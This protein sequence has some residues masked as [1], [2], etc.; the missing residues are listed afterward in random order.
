MASAS[1]PD[2][3]ESIA[4]FE[5]LTRLSS[6]DVRAVRA[7]SAVCRLLASRNDVWRIKSLER[8]GAL[9][10]AVVPD[11][12][13]SFWFGFYAHRCAMMAVAAAKSMRHVG[14]CDTWRALPCSA[15]GKE[16]D[17]VVLFLLS[18]RAE[19]SVDRRTLERSGSLRSGWCRR[20]SG[21]SPGSCLWRASWRLAPLVMFYRC[22]RGCSSG[23]E[24]Q[25]RWPRL[26]R[27]TCEPYS[28]PLECNPVYVRAASGCLRDVSARRCA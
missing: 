9:V 3:L 27:R 18:P 20:D 12:A 7:C 8:W 26:R 24:L 19:T 17:V 11:G 16:M 14:K 4:G 6:S 2:V 1:L 10:E 22:V 15:K 13:S 5:I 28:R 21:E 23:M 25:R